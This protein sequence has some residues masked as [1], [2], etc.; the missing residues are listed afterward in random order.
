MTTKRET[1]LQALLAQLTAAGLPIRRGEVLPARLPSGGVVILRDGEPGDPDVLLS[2]PLYYYQH[3]A[4]LE[5]VAANEIELDALFE[6]IGS[7]LAGDRTLGGTCDWV[8]AEAP[9]PV[10]LASDG[11]E[12]LKAALV[13]V[14]LHYWTNDP[15]G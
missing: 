3:R 8:I 9:S 2:A 14:V 4:E 15:L 6:M 11:A 10:D 5:V 7:A 12:T 13:Y 1:V